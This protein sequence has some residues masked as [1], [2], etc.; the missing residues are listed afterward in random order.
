VA[1]IRIGTYIQQHYPMPVDYVHPRSQVTLKPQENLFAAIVYAN[2][3]LKLTPDDFRYIDRLTLWQKMQQQ[4]D[5]IV[6]EPE[7]VPVE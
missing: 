7:L 4:I 5:A 6:P 1:E 3:E 2:N